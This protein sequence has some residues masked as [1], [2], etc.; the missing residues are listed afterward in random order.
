MK[1]FYHSADLDG[2]CSGAIVKMQKPECEMIGINYGDPFPWTS[3]ITGETVYM[4]D[5][6]LP[7]DEMERLNRICH[8]IWIDHHKSAIEEANARNFVASGHQ[9]LG[10]G[11]AAC[12]LTWME[13]FKGE[14]CRAVS[15]LGR[16]D[17]WDYG[18]HPG[19]LE[20]QYGM[21]QFNTTP[22]DTGFWKSIFF[23]DIQNIIEQGRSL[24]AYEEVQNEIFAKS[25]AFE[26]KFDGLNCIAV[27][28]GLTNSLLFQSVYDPERHDAMVAFVLRRPG[29][30]KVSIYTDK[31]EI[32]ASAICKAH[33]G[34]GHKKAAGFQCRTLPF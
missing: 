12:E 2:I 32:D 3:V 23:G 5:F 15:L 34:G 11:V 29:D 25:F 13:F 33:G 31:P 24:L 22:D 9:S 20:F 1:C 16:F 18:N 4:V 6:S 17:V 14:I 21:R 26:V 7:A 19:A 27:N 30:W 28:K 8:L 10:I